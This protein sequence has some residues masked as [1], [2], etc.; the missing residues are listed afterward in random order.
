VPHVVDPGPWIRHRIAE[1][2]AP[3]RAELAAAT[4]RGERVRLR[5]KIWQTTIRLRRTFRGGGPVKF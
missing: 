5:W 3:M 2:T 1:E 4:T